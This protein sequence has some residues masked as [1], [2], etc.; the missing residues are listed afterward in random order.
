MHDWTV[1]SPLKPVLVPQMLPCLPDID[2]LDILFTIR[3][4][5]KYLLRYSLFLIHS[6]YIFSFYN[7]SSV[8]LYWWRSSKFVPAACLQPRVISLTQQRHKFEHSCFRLRM[9]RLRMDDQ[10]GYLMTFTASLSHLLHW[11][12]TSPLLNRTILNPLKWLAYRLTPSCTYLL[13]WHADSV[14]HEKHSIK[15]DQIT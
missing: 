10:R 8:L 1:P 12:Q 3:V 4:V 9:D 2:V 13:T 6:I 7:F 11:P 14:H 5:K 15:D